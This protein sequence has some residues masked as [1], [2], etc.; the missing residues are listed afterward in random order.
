MQAEV[1]LLCLGRGGCPSRCYSSAGKGILAVEIQEKPQSHTTQQTSHKRFTG[2]EKSRKAAA[3]VMVRK[4]RELGRSQ[5]YIKLLGVGGSGWG[6]GARREEGILFS[7]PRDWSIIWP[8][9]EANSGIG[10]ILW[11]ALEA[12]RFVGFHAQGIG[13]VLLLFCLFVCFC[14]FFGPGLRLGVKLGSG[15]LFLGPFRLYI[16]GV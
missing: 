3:S 11:P 1:S 13:G 16:Y 5:G 15:C 14:L 2:R 10:G 7:V 9:L 6:G 8:N 12:Q 4:S